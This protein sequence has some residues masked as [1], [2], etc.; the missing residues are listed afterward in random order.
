[1][2]NSGFVQQKTLSTYIKLINHLSLSTL[3]F[4]RGCQVP[5]HAGSP[6]YASWT[7]ESLKFTRRLDNKQT[8]KQLPQ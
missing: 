3:I 8:P 7:G 1:M 6:S 4:N 2:T 5:V